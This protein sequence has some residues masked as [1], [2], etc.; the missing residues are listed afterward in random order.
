MAKVL[1]IDDDKSVCKM[2]S[3]MVKHMEHDAT[4]VHTIKNGLKK[5][6]SEQFDVVFLDVMLPDG[7]GLDIIPEIR[8]TDSSP[9]VIIMT[10]YGSPDGAEIAIKN[11]A[12]DY[13]QKPVTP[14]KIALPLKRILQYH[15]DLK[16]TQKTTV[17]L[18]LDGIVGRSPQ[19]RA[20]FDLLAQAADSEANVLITGETGTGKELFAKAIH[21]NSLRSDKNWVVVDCTVIPESL[22]ESVLLGHEKGAFTGADKAQD[23]VIIQAHGGTLFLDEV[24]ELPVSLQK[25]FLRVLQ[26]R[27]FRPIGSKQEVESNFRLV[28]AT[29]RDLDLMV[30]KGQFRKDLLY[31]IRSLTIEIPPLRQRLE[32]IKELLV[33]YVAKICES[34]R[35]E[36]KGISPDFFDALYVYDWPGNVREL[37]NTIERAVLEARQ[38]PTLFPKHLPTHIR[39]QAARSSVRETMKPPVKGI[40]LEK[41]AL[42][43]TLGRFR[44]VREATLAEMEK[45]Y[46][47]E[48]IELTKG[49]IKEACRVSGLGRN[50]LYIY[51]KRHNISR[52]GWE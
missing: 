44:E 7:S 21:S 25:A 1:I 22:V 5:V 30:K 26:E 39:I 40:P 47:Q 10:G 29:N 28:T 3:E 20:C 12:W 33:Y 9:E 23:G 18:K 27:R 24:G 38:E 13:I 43:E 36:T 11:G 31:R 32:D 48:L 50:R 19:M 8:G 51:L 46:F 4:A 41:S 45:N 37:I 52:L 2:L 17:A 49:S 14:K 15:D 42:T 34:Y 35:L 16:K 6:I